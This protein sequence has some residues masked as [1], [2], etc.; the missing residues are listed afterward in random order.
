MSIWNPW[1]GC[2]KYSEGCLN[3]YVYRRD[4]SI[5]KDASLV[6]KNA[7]FDLPLKKNRAKEYKIPSG[8]TLYTCMSSDFFISEADEWRPDI[9]SIIKQRTDISFIIITKRIIRFWEC[10]PNDWGDGYDNVVICSTIENQRQCDIRLPFFSELPIK[11]KMICCEPLLE[12][13]NLNGYL[14]DKI[15]LVVAGGESGNDSRV[16]DYKW[17]LSLREQCELRKVNFH[18]K[19]TGAKFL[20]DGRLFDIPRKLQMT[21]ASKAGLDI[22]FN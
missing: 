22:Y 2:R 19:Q 21:Q 10:I 17:I 6:T 15:S 12:E 4:E 16:C 7:D 11:R 5:G 3:C 1:H 20:K 9:W 13:I 8:E 14:S 18:F